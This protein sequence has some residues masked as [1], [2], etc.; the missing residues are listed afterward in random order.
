MNYNR[1]ILDSYYEHLVRIIDPDNSHANYTK[2][3]DKLFHA[4]YF[5][6]YGSNDKNR[7]V[8]GTDLRKKYD[9][10]LP[11]DFKDGFPCTVLEMMIALAVRI[12]VDI[13]GEPGDDHPERWFWAMVNNSG[14]G[15]LTNNQF[16]DDM[17]ETMIFDILGHR[18][19]AE[20]NGSFF[21]LKAKVG[22]DARQMELWQQANA[23]L[24][25]NYGY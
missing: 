22:R 20:G 11:I 15:V 13:M 18:F 21:P 5:H 8:D 24:I 3:L 2:L 7:A 23:W 6:K 9:G 1:N 14:L 19:D 10:Y 25:E 16:D 4:K 17:F 12:E